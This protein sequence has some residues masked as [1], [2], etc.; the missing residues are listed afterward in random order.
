MDRN[1]GWCLVGEFNE[2]M[3]NSEKIGGPS[4]HEASFD[5]FRSFARVCRLKEV[6]SSGNKIS[7][8]GVREVISNGIKENVWIQCWF[9]RAFGNAEW[10]RLFPR[11][12]GKYLERL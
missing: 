1:D 12:H 8:E 3:N 9:D 7:W 2:I 10:F 11:S 5:P 6:P 4:R